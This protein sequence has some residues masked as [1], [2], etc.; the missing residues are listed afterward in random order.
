MLVSCSLLS[1]LALVVETDEVRQPL[2]QA[3]RRFAGLGADI[4]E[5]QPD[6]LD[7][8][9]RPIALAVGMQDAGRAFYD[10]M[11][12]YIRESTDSQQRMDIVYAL[13]HATD[14]AT[15]NLIRVLALSDEL[16]SSELWWYLYWSLDR[17]DND[18]NWDWLRQNFDQLKQ[19]NYRNLFEKYGGKNHQHAGWHGDGG[20]A[21]ARSALGH[22]GADQ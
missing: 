21:E 19:L 15:I 11:T 7:P 5:I 13:A 22:A 20:R 4:V 6:A 10:L 16:R 2:T 17:A 14:R 1:F 18:S 9:I 12:R 8:D 3:A